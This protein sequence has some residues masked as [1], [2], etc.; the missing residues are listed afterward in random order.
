MG[1]RT[2]TFLEMQTRLLA[3]VPGLATVALYNGQGQMMKG[4]T[5]EH[6]PYTLPAVFIAF[7]GGEWYIERDL[8]RYSDQYV[9]RLHY[10]DQVYQDDDNRSANQAAAIN[11]LDAIDAVVNALDQ[12]QGLTYAGRVE[13]SGELL[14]EDRTHIIEHQLEF[15]AKVCDPS[16]KDKD[17]AATTTRQADDTDI[18]RTG[19]SQHEGV[20]DNNQVE[21]VAP[22]NNPYRIS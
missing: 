17:Q 4:E 21:L 2:A 18:I 13:F 14:D 1:W 8:V 16:L 22:E 12:W 11:H 6:I 7:Q 19:Q 5:N 20:I 3:E 10:I 9:F 15:Y